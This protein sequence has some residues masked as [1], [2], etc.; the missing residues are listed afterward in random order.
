MGLFAD[1]QTKLGSLYTVWKDQSKPD[2]TRAIAFT[3]YIYEGYFYSRPDSTAL[4]AGQLY[5]FTR[6]IDYK[7][8]MVDTLEL[9]GYNYFRMGDYPK[10][11]EL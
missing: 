9:A 7:K 6:K 5:N 1:A 4:L 2:T 11:I 8:G 3:K 10:S